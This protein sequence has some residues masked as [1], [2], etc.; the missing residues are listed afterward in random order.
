MHLSEPLCTFLN[1]TPSNGYPFRTPR[2]HDWPS[3]L[4]PASHPPS[5]P[6]TPTL[7]LL[8]HESAPSGY[9]ARL[10]SYHES[11]SHPSAPYQIPYTHTRHHSRSS[12]GSA[13]SIY[14]TSAVY[15]SFTNR[16]GL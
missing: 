14:S 12:Y 2:R 15:G 4:L 5:P 3:A 8:S 11:L 10:A 9:H 1:Y 7:S 6:H 16:P 13:S